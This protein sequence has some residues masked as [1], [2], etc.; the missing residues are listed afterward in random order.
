MWNLL[1]LAVLSSGN[2]VV[3]SGLHPASTLPLAIPINKVEKNS[4]Q[5]PVAKIVITS[6]II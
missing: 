3:I 6:P 1:S 5:K 4:D 2:K